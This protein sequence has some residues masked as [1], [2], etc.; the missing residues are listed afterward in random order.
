MEKYYE[1]MIR[2]TGDDIIQ[3]VNKEYDDKVYHQFRLPFDENAMRN[4]KLFVELVKIARE[5]YH[6][7]L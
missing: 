2:Q 5:N 1:L 3:K 6:G 4:A 7:V